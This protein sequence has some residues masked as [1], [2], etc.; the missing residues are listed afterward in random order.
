MKRKEKR[1]ELFFSFS[2]FL[3][4]LFSLRHGKILA[5]TMAQ[6]I[7]RMLGLEDKSAHPGHKGEERREEKREQRGEK[8]RS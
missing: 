6:I 3:Q 5:K 4:L 2:I 7:K 8:E 1:F